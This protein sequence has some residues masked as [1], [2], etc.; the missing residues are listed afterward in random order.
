MPS[1]EDRLWDAT[2]GYDPFVT[3][4][5]SDVNK[6]LIRL[7]RGLLAGLDRALE[8]FDD[9]DDFSAEVL[10][11]LLYRTAKQLDAVNELTT[12]ID[13]AYEKRFQALQNTAI[14]DLARHV[15]IVSPGAP[16]PE[17]NPL[18]PTAATRLRT[19]IQQYSRQHPKY[20]K[21]V[22]RNA[23]RKA[24]GVSKKVAEL[25]ARLRDLLRIVFKGALSRTERLVQFEAATAYNQTQQAAVEKINLVLIAQQ[26]PILLYRWDARRDKKT[27]LTCR[28]LDGQIRKYGE[29]YGMGYKAPPI[30]NHCRCY[31][32]VFQATPGAKTE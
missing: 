3:A 32:F 7:E 22:L 1:E 4:V 24:V 10:L 5:V 13:T 29:P 20:L 14:S 6:T 18:T 28:A 19:N 15:E 31:L 16:A 27:C 12:A 11:L 26:E 25:K 21:S 9:E 23:L 30:H 17:A 2:V 8:S